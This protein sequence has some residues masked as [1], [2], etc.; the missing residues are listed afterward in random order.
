MN[1]SSRNP[2]LSLKLEGWRSRLLL[3]LLC[4]LFLG[5]A[6]RAAYLQGVRHDFLQQKGEARYGRVIELPA[7]RGIVYDRNG[8]ALAISTPMESVWA[9]PPDANLSATQVAKLAKILHVDK[10][11][12]EENLDDKDRGF[13]YLKRQVSPELA[14]AV[15][16]LNIPGVFLRREYKRFY[17]AG[18][19]MAH[20]LGFTGIDDTGQE[21][22]ELA[23]QSSLA[24]SPGKK[25]V[26]KDRAGHTVEDVESIRL[27]QDGKSLTLS[28]D[29]RIQYLAY[30][31]LRDSVQANRAKAG[32][33]VVLDVRTGEIVALA[34]MPDYNPNNRLGIKPAQMRNR[35]AIDMFEPGSTLKPFTVAAAIEA[36][37]ISPNTV[38][39]TAPG[40]LTVGDRTI[41]DAHPQG[42]L[43]V[44]Q[45]IQKSSNVGSAKI[46]LSL[47]A[48][49]MWDMFN[50][51][52][53][54]AAPHSGI[55]GESS[56]RVRPYKTWRP[57]EQATMSYGHGIS[58]SLLQLARAYTAFATGGEIRPVTLLKMEGDAVGER[59]IS[60]RT[61]KAVAAMLEMAV[62]PGGTAP[63]AQVPGY[64]VAGKTG[65]AHK[66]IAGHYAGNV[67]VSSFVG[68]AP[69]SSPR[70]VIAVMIDEPSAG[71][72]YGGAVAAPVFS[73]VMGGA[74]RS[75][76]IVPDSP[77][78][79]WSDPVLSAPEIK[80][81]A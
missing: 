9:S 61:A 81:E 43:T 55:P 42:D 52:G 64:R 30:R 6:A 24:G 62:Q 35:P 19:V 54:G 10:K 68:F 37:K 20:V 76:G 69:A 73:K 33:I 7:N 77:P 15:T 18:E 21:G 40:S 14:T 65:T 38:I 79:E 75:Y 3:V 46:A 78:K 25:R 32:S 23:F 50:S 71:Q 27:P 44:A 57:I 5:L 72:Y 17:P 28:L 56:G 51:V 29:S 67:Y 48:E 45:V 22:L 16:A 26:I 2:A 47:P 49:K 34:S 74:L 66:Q 70:F 13:V 12:I 60:E 80:E 39:S 59:I 1:Y 8:E 41:H 53:F 63:K 31:E 58:V 4:M 11:E 36:G